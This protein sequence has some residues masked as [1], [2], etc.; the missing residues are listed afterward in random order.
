MFFFSYTPNVKEI[1]HRLF[2]V[3]TVLVKRFVVCYC[4]YYPRHNMQ[5]NTISTC[6]TY[7]WNTEN[8]LHNRSKSRE[9]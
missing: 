9:L 2:V 6:F 7:R 4:I 8:C 3:K 5:Y 1:R